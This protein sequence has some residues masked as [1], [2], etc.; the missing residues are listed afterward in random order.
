MDHET[1]I[2][3]ALSLQATSSYGVWHHLFS[4]LHKKPVTKFVMCSVAS[5][6]GVVQAP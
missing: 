3:A 4:I 6:L 5:S 2:S 1:G